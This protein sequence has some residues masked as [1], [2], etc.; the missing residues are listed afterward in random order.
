VDPEKAGDS[1]VVLG[2]E[3]TDSGDSYAVELRNSILEITPGPLPDGMPAVRLTAQQLRDVLAGKPAPADAGDTAA[4][5]G[6]VA[7]LDRD[8]QGFY[9]H[10]R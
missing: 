2:F 4:L 3:F 7:C 10:V 6:M 1:R 5:A 9:M 8:S